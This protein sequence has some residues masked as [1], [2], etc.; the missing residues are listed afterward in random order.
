M[1]RRRDRHDPRHLRNL[2]A[3]TGWIAWLETRR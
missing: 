2:A 1:S 3:M